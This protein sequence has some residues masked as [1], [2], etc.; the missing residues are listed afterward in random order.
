VGVLVVTAEKNIRTILV[1]RLSSIGDIVLTTPL[2]T[3][4]H[5]AC[6]GAKIDYCTKASFRSLLTAN[7]VLHSVYTPDDLTALAYDLVID[8][9]NNARSRALTRRIQAGQIRRYHKKNWKKALL[10]Y[11]RIHSGDAYHSVVE[12]YAEAVR[13]LV[14]SV[15]A[16]CALHPSSADRAYAATAVGSGRPVLVLCFGANHFTKRYPA[17][18]FAGIVEQVLASTSATI[19][20]L[21]GKEDVAEAE[22]IMNA[23]TQE[24]HRRITLLSGA[25]TLMQSA[26]ILEMSDLV[27]CNDTGLMHMASAFGKKL[28][29][30][31]GSSVSEFG[32]LPWR[33]SFELFETAGLNC[34]PC[35]HIGRSVCPKNHFRCM[36]E[37]APE[38]ISARIVETLNH[39][40]G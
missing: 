20:L 29:V 9:Q 33:T 19:V 13:D 11:F 4:L 37:I 25:S 10:V 28:F 1:I 36:N 21:G 2:L 32:F 30:I 23:L 15:K 40:A 17:E 8:L 24:A 34:R 38:R 27:L 18:R 3:E 31:F 22:K 7:P 14:P 12:R 6:P 39:P 5:H 35:S 26:A 16:S